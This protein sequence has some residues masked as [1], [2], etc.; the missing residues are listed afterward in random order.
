MANNN[1]KNLVKRLNKK[2]EEAFGMIYELY[3]NKIYRFVIFKVSDER[4]AQEIVQDVFIKLWRVVEK[5]EIVLNV[6]ALLYKIARFRVIDYYRSADYSRDE[7]SI[8]DVISDELTVED[9]TEE[10]IDINYDIEV[11]QNALKELPIIYQEVIT[12]K[13][14]EEKTNKEIALIIDKDESNVRVIS[15][16]AIKALKKILIDK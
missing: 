3:I 15:H 2:D 8:D 14:I 13:F 4:I 11:I 7:V 5:G 6:S 10:I 16:R 9:E 1:E 12:L